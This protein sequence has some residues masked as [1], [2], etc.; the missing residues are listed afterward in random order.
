MGT[1]ALSLCNFSCHEIL[2]YGLDLAPYSK[3]NLDIVFAEQV[4]CPWA[5]AAC[6]D[7]RDLMRGKEWRQLSRFVPGA[8]E[9]LL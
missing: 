1:A 4:H 3:E 7:V 2:D 9:N 5:H 8:L 6:K